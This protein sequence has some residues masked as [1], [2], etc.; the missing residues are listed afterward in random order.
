[1]YTSFIIMRF[2]KNLHIKILKYYQFITKNFDPNLKMEKISHTRD[3]DMNL[4]PPSFHARHKNNV[5]LKKEEP[6][7]HPLQ[8]TLHSL[9][10]GKKYRT[11]EQ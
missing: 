2:K 4:S 1:M 6:S 7:K 5:K 3:C 11:I 9:R 8:L 10:K